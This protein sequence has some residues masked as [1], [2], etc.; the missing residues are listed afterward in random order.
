MKF[1]LIK[2]EKRNLSIAYSGISLGQSYAQGDQRTLTRDALR[3]MKGF[4][5]KA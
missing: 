1:K 4:F 2:L 5:P 3:E